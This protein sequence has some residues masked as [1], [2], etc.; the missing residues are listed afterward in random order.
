MPASFQPHHFFFLLRRLETPCYALSS[1]RSTEDDLERERREKERNGDNA[2]G[3]KGDKDNGILRGE[4]NNVSS[5]I[6]HLIDYRVEDERN[7]Q[8]RST[9]YAGA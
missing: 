1:V 3:R 9:G 7:K 2:R 6:V 8:R 5:I 4:N